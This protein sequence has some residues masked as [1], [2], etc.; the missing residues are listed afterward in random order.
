MVEVEK[1]NNTLLNIFQSEIIYA[2]DVYSIDQ[3]KLVRNWYLL[4]L[5]LNIIM[6]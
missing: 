1:T 2:I 5:D 4:D 6:L 3:S